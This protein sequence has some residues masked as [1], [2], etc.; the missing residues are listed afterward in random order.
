MNIIHGRDFV[1]SAELVRSV[2]EKI[3][4]KLS[5]ETITQDKIDRL[6]LEELQDLNKLVGLANF[7]LCKYDDK[8]DTRDMLQYFVSLIDSTCESM[9]GIDDEIAEL[10]IAAED[11]INRIKATHTTISDKSDLKSVSTQG[12]LDSCA[13]NLTNSTIEINPLE[14][15]QNLQDNNN[16]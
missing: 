16:R 13:N 7:L 1:K 14:Y 4:K 3:N 9:G 5:K 15:Q 2:S 10:L 6:S 11:S 12:G 8:R